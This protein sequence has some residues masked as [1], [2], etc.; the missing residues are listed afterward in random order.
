MQKTYSS[1]GEGEGDQKQD[2][3][4]AVIYITSQG[5]GRTILLAIISGWPI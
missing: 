5:S 2:H 1:C 3:E 4:A